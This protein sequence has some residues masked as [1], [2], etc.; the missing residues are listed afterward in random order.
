M[1]NRFQTSLEYLLCERRL[2]VAGGRKYR[3]VKHAVR[4][5]EG[6]DDTSFQGR[7]ASRGKHGHDKTAEASGERSAH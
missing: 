2:A 6:A 7:R 3:S 4:F 1:F 5:T